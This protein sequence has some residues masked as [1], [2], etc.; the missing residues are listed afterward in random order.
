M[1]CY[2]DNSAT[3]KP[4]DEVVKAMVKMLNSNYGNPSSLHHIGDMANYSLEH[5]RETLAKSFGCDKDEICFTASGTESNNIAI[6][7][8]AHAMKRRGNRIVTTS[9]EHPS[10]LEC[11]NQLESEG[12]EVIRLRVDENGFVSENELFD[13][14]NEN[15]ILISMMYVNNE[16]G[17]IQP[18]KLI[19]TAVRRVGAPAIIHCDAVQAYGKL[20]CDVKD[21]GVDIMSV[22]AHKIHGPK[23]V[24]ALYIKKGTRLAPYI[25][26]GGQ[27]NGVRS[28]TQNM[29]GIVGFATAVDE[30][31]DIDA[32]YRHVAELKKQLCDKISEMDGIQINSN[33]VFPYITNISILGVPSEV[34]RNYLS[35][36]SIY[37][38]TGSACSKGHRS[39]VLKGMGMDVKDID[40]AIRISFSRYN[41]KE[42]V[43]Y[44]IEALVEAKEKLR[45][46]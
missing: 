16:V 26:G 10:V 42:E 39:Y 14:V 36:K 38:S 3:T 21:L 41:T 43:D 34:L 24:G 27:E 1:E 46:V 28:G 23:G 40:S 5:A 22:S 13:A 8:V 4:S 44:L 30:I 32:N 45:K 29:P 33:S 37:V 9:I 18:V 6:M 11:M 15:T 12:F 7:G 17:T 31:G 20:S 25:L 35:S 19:R 2:F